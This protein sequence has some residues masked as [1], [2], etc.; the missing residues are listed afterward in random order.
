MFG[1]S[2]EPEASA[3]LESVVTSR[4]LE[5]VCIDFWSVEDSSNKSLDVLVVNTTSSVCTAFPS[6]CTQIRVLTLRVV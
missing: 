4:P 1:K 2:P 3:P 6:M 5:M